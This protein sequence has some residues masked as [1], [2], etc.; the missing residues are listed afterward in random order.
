M[1]PQQ[2]AQFILKRHL[3][4]MLFLA[5]DVFLHLI[6][7]GLAHEADATPLGLGIGWTIDPR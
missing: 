4:M 2:R 6:Q 1:F 3:A 5:R 7:I